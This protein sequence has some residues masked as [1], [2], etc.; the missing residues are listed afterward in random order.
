[1]TLSVLEKLTQFCIEISSARWLL[2]LNKYVE[3]KQSSIEWR[4]HKNILCPIYMFML[5]KV[6]VVLNVFVF[7]DNLFGIEI[8]IIILICLSKISYWLQRVANNC[9]TR[10]GAIIILSDWYLHIENK[11]RFIRKLITREQVD[12]FS[13]FLIRCVCLH[14]E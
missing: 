7:F 9:K 3:S 10:C 4:L 14:P 1:M 6:L 11:V 12:R 5:P 2:A 8:I 13:W